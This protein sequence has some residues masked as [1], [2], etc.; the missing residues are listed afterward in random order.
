M[1]ASGESKVWD[2]TEDS[3]H[4]GLGKIITELKAADKMW[5][6]DVHQS[7][8]SIPAFAPNIITGTT[9]GELLIWTY[10]RS[11]SAQKSIRVKAHEDRINNV[12]FHQTGS[13]F[14]TASYD[15]SWSIWDSSRM[16][17][18]SNQKGHLK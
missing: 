17:L 4:E 9:L 14:F 7:I 18:L 3:E 15:R 8:G 5:D 2:L 6:V 1:G 13:I 11:L 10:D 16:K 12:K